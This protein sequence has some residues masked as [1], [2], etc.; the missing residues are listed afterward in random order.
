[1]ILLKQLK[2]LLAQ[3]PDDAIITLDGNTN[4]GDIVSA[5]MTWEL[6]DPRPVVNLKL[7]D[8]WSVTLDSVTDEMVRQ[9]RNAFDADQPC[10]EMR[11]GSN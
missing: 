9:M 6:G 10:I 1:M 3:F 11:T 7:A 8:G 5:E 2:E 4:G